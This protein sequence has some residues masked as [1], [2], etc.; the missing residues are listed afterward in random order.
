MNIAEAKLVVETALLCAPE[1]LSVNELKNLFLEHAD[2]EFGADKVLELLE[3]LRNDWSDRGVELV[4][5]SSGWRFQSRP[6]M[7]KYLD[8]L[9]P[10]KPPKY[11]RATMETLAII[12]YH[13]P[14]TRGDIEEIRGVTVNS[15]IIRMLEERGWIETV[16]QRNVPGRPSLLATTKQF[17]DDLGLTS[18]QHLPTL[19][20]M[21]GSELQAGDSIDTSYLENALPPNPNQTAI[22]F[23]DGNDTIQVAAAADQAV[24]TALTEVSP[25]SNSPSNT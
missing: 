21:D 25:G 3:E 8:R 15:Q 12:A 13:Q 4:N 14:V 19:L 6:E 20:L 17:L 18:L 2:A 9:N 16:G 23:A 5:L 1:P 10:E 7:K 11:S 24:T 22:D